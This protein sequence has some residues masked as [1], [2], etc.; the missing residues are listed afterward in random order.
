MSLT[1]PNKVL[2]VV[3]KADLDAQFTAISDYVNTTK[4]T[5]QAVEPQGIE[6]RHLSKPVKINLMVDKDPV[7]IGATGY[8][9][10][11]ASNAVLKHVSAGSD[12]SYPV[13][14]VE[15]MVGCTNANAGAGYPTMCAIGISTDAGA[16]WSVIL[17]T[18][19]DL[20]NGC[21]D[22]IPY[23]DAVLQPH[24]LTEAANALPVNIPSDRPVELLATFGGEKSMGSLASINQYCVMFDADG[25]GANFYCW[26]ILMLD[27]RKST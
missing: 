20:G 26:A 13:V 8:G 27:A 19:R 18:K 15:G 25:S 2:A 3:S 14:F 1:L 7:V 23:Y 16:T 17:A 21:G 5:V 10:W 9:G 4:I 22:A 24:Y 6:Y 11:Y 12:G